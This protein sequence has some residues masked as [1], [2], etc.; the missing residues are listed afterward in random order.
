V[1]PVTFNSG[2]QQAYTPL[3]VQKPGPQ[4][5]SLSGSSVS[6]S[7]APGDSL[8]LSPAALQ[9]AAL[10]GRVAADAQTG[11]LT[12]DQAQQLYSQISTI[13]STIVA[14][15]HADG[16]SLSPIDA[17]AIQQSQ[18]QLSQTIY[19]DAHAGA[20]PPS[21]PTRAGQRAATETGRI[22]ADQKAGNLSADQAQQLGSQLSAIQQQIA[23]DEH[24][25]GGSLSKSDAQAINQLQNQ[26]SDQ[27]YEAAHGAAP[28]QSAVPA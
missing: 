17:Q 9:E 25:N 3:P 15:R 24:A 6:A 18:S 20:A 13:H 11:S 12:A 5:G 14:D 21:D 2:T 26:F 7:G 22:V 16:G 10:T 1:T 27:I 28:S 4:A 19:G 23:S 8:H